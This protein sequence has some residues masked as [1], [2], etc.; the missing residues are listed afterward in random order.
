MERDRNYITYIEGN[1][2]R[3]AE[4]AERP[5]RSYED[6]RRVRENPRKLEQQR[7][8]L[9]MNGA[10]VVFLAASVV[11]CLSLCIY[12][13]NIQAQI[14]QTQSEI[15]SLS[16]EISALT[17]ENEALDYEV[18]AYVDLDYIYDIAMNELG[19]VLPDGSQVSLYERSNSEYVT[20]IWDIPEE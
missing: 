20:Q 6:G 2:V 1:A 5:D 8:S 14:K 13:L 16:S 15:K 3:I 4:P 10:Y 7:R 19:M 9:S 11:V 18:N 12:Y 17:T